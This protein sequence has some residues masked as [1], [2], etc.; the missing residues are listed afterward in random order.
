MERARGSPVR[1]SRETPW[2]HH[3]G[4]A[5]FVALTCTGLAALLGWQMARHWPEVP[6]SERWWIGLFVVAFGLVGLIALYAGIHQLLASLVAETIVE[7]DRPAVAPSESLLVKF[8]QPGPVRLRS[9]RARLIRKTIV[10]PTEAERRRSDTARDKDFYEFY[11]RFLD[12]P[13]MVALRGGCA[14]VS[15]ELAIPRDARLSGQHGLERIQWLIEVWGRVRFWPGFMHQ[16][17]V[18]VEGP[19][20]GKHA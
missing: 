13:D 18:V 6:T 12:A 5:Y 14:E 19:R 8:R 16:F 3:R 9:L 10:S 15:A 20:R 17:E 2:A 1:L 7:I 11:Q 4:A